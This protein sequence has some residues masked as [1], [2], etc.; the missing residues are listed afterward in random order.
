MALVG[1][2][3]LL[4]E[5]SENGLMVR[6]QRVP[7]HTIVKRRADAAYEE[8]F[9]FYFE[10]CAGSQYQSKLTGG[11]GTGCPAMRCFI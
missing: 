8:L 11:K 9:P 4:G 1:F 10:L 2:S 5:C 3:A 7:E 6:F